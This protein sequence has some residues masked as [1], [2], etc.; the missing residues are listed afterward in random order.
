MAQLMGADCRLWSESRESADAGQT[1]IRTANGTNSGV[2]FKITY[3]SG[4]T[5][6]GRYF[7]GIVSNYMYS[8]ED[9]DSIAG[10]T[11]TIQ[12]NTDMI[13]ATS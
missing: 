12:R 3:P 7:Y 10:A 5:P 8:A 11:F 13:D 1:V 9:A 4:S 2:A 6:V